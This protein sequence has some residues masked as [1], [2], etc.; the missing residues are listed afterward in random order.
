MVLGDVPRV[1]RDDEMGAP[2]IVGCALWSGTV[3]TRRRRDIGSP[4]VSVCGMEGSGV[5]G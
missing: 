3:T 2:E 1:I 5:D 4:R